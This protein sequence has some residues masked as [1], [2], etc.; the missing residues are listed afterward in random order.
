MKI[1]SVREDSEEGVNECDRADSII[2]GEVG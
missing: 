2:G 1:S